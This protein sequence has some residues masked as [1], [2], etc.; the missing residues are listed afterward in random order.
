MLEQTASKAIFNKRYPIPFIRTNLTTLN[1]QT[2]KVQLLYCTEYT[3][4]VLRKHQL[5]SINEQDIQ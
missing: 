5:F 3:S 2:H 1:V 4:S